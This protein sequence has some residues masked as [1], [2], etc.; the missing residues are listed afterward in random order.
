MHLFWRIRMLLALK[1]HPLV[2]EQFVG[3]FNLTLGNVPTS[4]AW[5]FGD[6]HTSVL[7]APL[8]TFTAP[9]VFNI[10]LVATNSGGSDT[11]YVDYEVLNTPTQAVATMR[12]VNEEGNTVST[13]NTGIDKANPDYAYPILV[14]DTVGTGINPPLTYIGDY[15]Q[16]E[17][18]RQ[19]A[20]S[21]LWI[22][23][24]VGAVYA[25]Y[26]GQ[27][28]YTLYP[29]TTTM[30][31]NGGTRA[32]QGYSYERGYIEGTYKAQLT[33]HNSSGYATTTLATATVV[34]RDNPTS[35][36]NLGD[37]L[38][39]L[40]GLGLQLIVSVIIILILMIIPYLWTRTF[41]VYLEII[42]AIVGI[43]LIYFLHLIDIWIIVALVGV[44]LL[45]VFFMNRGSGGTPPE[46]GEVG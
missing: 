10:T 45:I 40:G 37:W 33:L 1:D 4:W 35:F 28:A 30:P 17:I 16:I 26:T 42:M 19:D 9:G 2:D 18:F 23:D 6:G 46:G 43:G 21:G 44:S 20:S 14:F 8:H 25:R 11:C 24:W 32:F 12:W 13:I 3:S 5:D 15:F 7:E 31:T 34:V 36:G 22:Q 39:N 38:G 29:S 41:N 27:S